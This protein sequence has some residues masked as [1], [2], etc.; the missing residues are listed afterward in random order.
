MHV[1]LNGT[2]SG[3]SYAFRLN[4]DYFEALVLNGFATYIRDQVTKSNATSVSVELQFQNT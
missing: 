3:Q 4:V 1:N 2:Y